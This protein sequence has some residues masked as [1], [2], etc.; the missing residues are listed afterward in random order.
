MNR[1]LNE[2]FFR[3][4]GMRPRTKETAILM[5]VDAIE[6]ASRTIDPP[7]REKFEE[8]VQRIIFVKLK[9]GQLDESGLTLQDLRTMST[10]LVD[11]L[12]N[13]HHTRI[14]YPWQDRK[15]KGEKQ[16][17][18]PGAATEAEVVRAREES[19][20]EDEEHEAAQAQEEE[21]H[22]DH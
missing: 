22:H 2:N 5:L 10:Q 14:R 20:R 21:A 12:C 9:Q 8:M 18:I 16:L 15:D 1:N 13:V 17:P 6:A 11:T 3:Y 19:A 4:P 7:E